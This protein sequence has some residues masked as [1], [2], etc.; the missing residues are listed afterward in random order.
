VHDENYQDVEGLLKSRP[1]L[2]Q[3]ELSSWAEGVLMMPSNRNKRALVELLLGYD[4]KVPAISKWGRFYYFKHDVIAAFLLDNGMS[5]AHTTWHHVTLL[6]DMAQ[7]GDIPK[8]KLLLDHGAEINAVDEE[9]R[10]APIGLAARWGRRDMVAFLLARGADP[11][12]CGTTWS[13][14]LRIVGIRAVFQHR[15]VGVAV[16]FLCGRV[17][18]RAQI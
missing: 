12:K 7:A 1:D 16:G 13:T 10:S 6:H 15:V 17:M 14:P 11:D 8:A 3:N 5:A 4:A 2:A 18:P 9:Y